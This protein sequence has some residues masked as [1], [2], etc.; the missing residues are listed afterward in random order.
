MPHGSQSTMSHSAIAHS[1]VF[2]IAILSIALLLPLT[3]I[4]KRTDNTIHFRS[5]HRYMI[6]VPVRVNGRGPYSFLLDTGATSSAVDPQLSSALHLAGA[7]GVQLASWDDTTDA[8]RVLVQSLS[9]G[10]IRS[11]PLRVLVQPL[12]QFKA[13]DPQLRGILGQD[14]LLRSNY[15]ID[16]RH[17]LIRFDNDG[18]LLQELVGDRVSIAPVLTSAGS[19]EP[20]LIAVAVHTVINAQPL[21]LLLDSGADMVVLQPL[22][23]PASAVP[24]GTKWIADENGNRS[25]ATTFHT[26]MSVG[27]ETFS[28]EAW[29][30]NT[31][32]KQLAIDG[33]LPTGSFDQLYIANRDSFVIFEPGRK[34]HGHRP[35]SPSTATS[36][37][38]NGLGCLTKEGSKDPPS[39]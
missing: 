26:L 33:L 3:A 10:T 19:L 8:R 2:R 11:G 16:N 24:L 32:L 34:R 25:A 4:A 15:L 17:H 13:F 9:L 12:V 7:Q 20:R 5:P 37:S 36:A 6:V 21:H 38:E 31:G 30:G 27:T 22:F 29:I 1:C 35:V 23:A 18:T 14:V 28:A 39:C